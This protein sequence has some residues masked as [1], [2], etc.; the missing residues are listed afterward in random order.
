MMYDQFYDYEYDKAEARS[1]LFDDLFE[2]IDKD[3]ITEFFS[4]LMGVDKKLICGEAVN[5]LQF[6]D[7]FKDVIQSVVDAK[8]EKRKEDEDQ[9]IIDDYETNQYYENQRS[10]A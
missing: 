8:A 6:S 7:V 4:E 3:N 9:K 10:I 5:R 2:R 1:N